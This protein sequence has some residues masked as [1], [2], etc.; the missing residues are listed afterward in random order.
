MKRDPEAGFTYLE[1]LTSLAIMALLAVL[2]TGSMSNGRQVWSRAQSFE[3][4]SE[5]ATLRG[6][7]RQWLQD[8][9]A[10]DLIEGNT[11]HLEF[12]TRFVD[13]PRPDIFE[14]TA[15]ISVRRNATYRELIVDLRGT[16]IDDQVIFE[17]TR[18]LV[19]NIATVEFTYY[20]RQASGEA[21]VW[22]DHWP[23]GAKG[24][25]LIKLETTQ[26]HIQEWPPLVIAVNSNIER[27]LWNER[28][29]MPRD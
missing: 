23:K 8:T 14:L 18:M 20:G 5:Q 9:E 28:S 10:L 27:K 13:M 1:L 15:K 29:L 21:I 19:A 7:I 26:D 3:T 25:K 22:H 11:D 24:L 16:D 4:L 2:L 17:E 12:T 6:K